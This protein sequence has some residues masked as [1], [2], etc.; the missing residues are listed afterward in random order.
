MQSRTSA[1]SG[2]DNA[3]ITYA[4]IA[5]MRCNV[6]SA[7]ASQLIGGRG[8]DQS[9]TPTHVVEFRRVPNLSNAN[10]ILMLNGPFKGIRFHI[11]DR[12]ISRLGRRIFM[13]AYTVGDKDEFSQ[14]TTPNLPDIFS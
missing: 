10:Y 3:T 11:D 9:R 5:K 8:S 2:T 12:I 4:T 1:E 13:G 7:A 14:P 6:E